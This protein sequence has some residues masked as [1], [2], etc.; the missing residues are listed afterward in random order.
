M[1]I[2][3]D[4]IST[5]ATH[6][7]AEERAANTIAKYV[8]D[9]RAFAAY[10]GGSLVT[11]ESAIAYKTAISATHAPASVN[12]M[13]AA[14]N[15]FFAYYN[16]GIKLK[17][18][19]VQRRAFAAEE[20]ELTRGEYSRLLAAAKSNERLNLLLQTI[21][22][23]GIRVSELR[24]ITAEAANSGTAEVTN[25]GKTRTVFLPHKLKTAL[26][27]YCRRRGIVSGSVFITS[28]GK[29]LNRSNIWA[30]MKKLCKNAN[31]APSKV[32]PHNLRHLFARTFYALDRDIAKLADIL[33]HSDINTTR[34][35]VKENSGE[36]RRRIEKLG[37]VT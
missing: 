29:P 3:N 5:Y 11:K 35:Y 13:L 30:E 25:K 26:Q 24:H 19:K 15:G 10:L 4:S 22:A 27:R 34:I 6:L 7:A 14:L 32:F 12:S 17:P 33:G 21:C 20:R 28:R 2:T 1:T 18:L 36:F 23:T 37:L 31:V 16:V 9:I 8:R